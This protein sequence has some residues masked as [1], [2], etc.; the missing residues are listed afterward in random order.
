MSREQGNENN[1]KDII[2]A[3]VG[4]TCGTIAAGSVGW[5][6]GAALNTEPRPLNEEPEMYLYNDMQDMDSFPLAEPLLGILGA[7]AGYSLSARNPAKGVLIGG[8]VLAG[9]YTINEILPQDDYI[10]DAPN[11]NIL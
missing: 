1:T 3:F 9:S 4:K 7:A 8:F 10:V 6:A 2:P 11:L 5:E